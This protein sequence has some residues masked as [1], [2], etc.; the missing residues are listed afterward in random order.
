MGNQQ[1]YQH[2]LESDLPLNYY[3]YLMKQ[4]HL[5]PHVIQGWYR[6]FINVCPNGQ[7]DQNQFVRFYKQ[8]ENSS[9]KSAYTKTA[10][11]KN[12]MK[13]QKQ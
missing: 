13:F 7:L 3:R 9:T 10:Y 4:T 6:E 5:T 1:Q 8:L 2:K 11:L 12:V